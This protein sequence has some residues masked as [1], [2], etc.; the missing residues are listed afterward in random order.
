MLLIPPDPGRFPSQAQAKGLGYKV[1][2]VR[3]VENGVAP[4][5]ELLAQRRTG[6]NQG[7]AGR[8][9]DRRD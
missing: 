4:V 1:L 6:F 3:P 2:A 5:S 7:A 8:Q 9:L